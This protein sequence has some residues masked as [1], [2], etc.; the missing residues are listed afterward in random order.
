M[1]NLSY[2][3]YII[4]VPLI[5]TPYISRVLGVET[6]GLFNFAQSIVDIFILVGCIG[7]NLYGQ[8][9]IAYVSDDP[10]KRSRTFFELQ[11]LRM[12]TI[13]ISILVYYFAIVRGSENSRIYLILIIELFASVFDIS[14]FFQGI[15]NFRLISIRNFIVKTAGIICIFAFVKNQSQLDVYCFWYGATIFLGNIS[16]WF[17]LKRNLVKSGLKKLRIFSHL[18]PSLIIFLP[19]ISTSIYTMLDKTMVGLLSNNFE[20]S[21][22]SQAEKIVK[23]ALTIVTSL[24]LIMMSRIAKNYYDDKMD[25]AKE[26][27]MKSFRLVFF[28]GIPIMFGL[29]G[30][31]HGLIP[32]FY[33][34]GYEPVA[35]VIMIISPLVMCIGLSGVTGVQYLM[36]TN[37]IKAYTS[38]VVAGMVVNIL[39]NFALIGRFGAIGAAVAS[40]VGEFVVMAV[41]F[42]FVRKTFKW[43]IMLKAW[44]NIVAA[45]VMLAV[46]V[47]LGRIL[48]YGPA[49]TTIIEIA[50]GGC[51]YGLLLLIMRDS[52]LLKILTGLMNR[53]KPNK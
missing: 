12:I 27:L 53:L 13:S 34:P 5:T 42:F 30:I 48:P 26:N 11:I 6:V 22:Y 9:Q 40:V 38:S 31:A 2:Q 23:L 18:L 52:F 35:P 44:K 29:A 21:Y 37:R 45:A 50:A 8:R 3:I 46:I 41:Q 47:L 4:I 20:V 33:G 49:Y 7:L 51:V 25:E 36:P 39:L 15:E 14:W 19:Q 1:Y 28:L 43:T 16:L 24:S 32:W 10:V 17:C